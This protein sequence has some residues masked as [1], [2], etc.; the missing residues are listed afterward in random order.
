MTLKST[1]LPTPAEL[2]TRQTMLSDLHELLGALLT[3]SEKPMGPLSYG[4]FLEWLDED[5]LAEWVD[6]SVIMTSPASLQH[7]QLVG[8]LDKVLGQY[9]LGKQLGELITAPFQM[10]L[11]NSGREPDLLYVKNEN[12]QRLKPTFLD[13]PADL[14]IEILSP[15][16]VSRDRGEKY[17]E[18]ASGGV[19]EYWLIDP[20]GSWCEFYR[21]TGERFQLAF[22]GGEG[23]YE[24]RAVSGFWIQVEWLWRKPLPLPLHILQKIDPTLI[25][26]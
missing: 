16:S 9:V 12:L 24:S 21:L 18:Y 25:S 10:K 26:E 11:A 17:Y 13:G 22:E 5:T 1:R 6:G 19:D 2:R 3:Q 23:R 8:F 4:E 15:E 14:V 7:Q 20:I